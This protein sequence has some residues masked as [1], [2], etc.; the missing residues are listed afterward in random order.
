ML[1]LKRKYAHAYKYDQ[2]A[3]KATG[4]VGDQSPSRGNKLNCRG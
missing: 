2:A 4:K 1:Y 3:E